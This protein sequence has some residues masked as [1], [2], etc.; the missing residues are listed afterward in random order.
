[1]CMFPIVDVVN[2][3]A[4]QFPIVD[5]VML[6]TAVQGHMHIWSPWQMNAQFRFGL[7]PR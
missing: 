1:M 7:I 6:G 2:Y 5:V 4:A 3:F